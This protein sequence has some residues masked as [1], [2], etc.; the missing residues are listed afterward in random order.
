[1]ELKELLNGF[2]DMKTPGKDNH[3]NCNYKCI[4]VGD[5]P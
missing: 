3:T 4:K 5:A 1:M 2:N